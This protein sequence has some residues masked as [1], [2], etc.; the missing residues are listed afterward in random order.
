M[1]GVYVCVRVCVCICV[2]GGDTPVLMGI[3]YRNVHQDILLYLN[4]IYIGFGHRVE[5]VRDNVMFKQT[6]PNDLKVRQILVT[7]YTTAAT[8]ALCKKKN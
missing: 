6:Q 5:Y 7:N 8:K 2:W 1:L 3:G 4:S